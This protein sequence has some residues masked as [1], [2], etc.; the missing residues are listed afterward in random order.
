M[1]QGKKDAA[2]NRAGGAEIDELTRAHDQITLGLIGWDKS[3][4]ILSI[5]S[6]LIFLLSSNQS[7]ELISRPYRAPEPDAPPLK[8]AATALVGTVVFAA[9]IV[10]MVWV[11]YKRLEQQRLKLEQGVE[12]TE[13]WPQILIVVTGFVFIV[14]TALRAIAVRQKQEDEARVVIL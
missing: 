9:S 5:L 13:L 14:M 10:G 2:P 3:F 12:T 1:L 6:Q 8:P 4:T 11:A 7:I